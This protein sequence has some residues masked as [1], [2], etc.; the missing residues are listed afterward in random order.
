MRGSWKKRYYAYHFFFNCYEP[1]APLVLEQYPF[2]LMSNSVRE[3]H[4]QIPARKRDLYNRS[5]FFPRR[6]TGYF[7]EHDA[8][9]GLF[10]SA[11]P[12]A[13]MPFGI[14]QFFLYSSRSTKAF[15]MSLFST[16]SFLNPKYTIKYSEGGRRLFIWNCGS[17]E[18]NI[19]FVLSILSDLIH[20]VNF[21]SY[22]SCFLTQI[23]IFH[24]LFRE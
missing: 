9:S 19:I 7:I 14:F 8:T 16:L 1:P 17:L 24:A 11:Q 4:Q 12:I 13:W 15:F 2:L 21:L 23:N 10:Y 6:F 20:D 18:F 5:I 3:L 22:T